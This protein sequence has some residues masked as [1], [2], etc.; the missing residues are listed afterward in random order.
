MP[1]KSYTFVPDVGDVGDVD[2]GRD[3]MLQ[4]Y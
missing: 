2:T 1:L 3:E 4:M